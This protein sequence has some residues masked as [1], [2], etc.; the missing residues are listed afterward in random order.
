MGYSITSSDQ[1]ID[2]DT[3]IRGCEQ[4]IKAADELDVNDS[5]IDAAIST[6]GKNVCNISDNSRLYSEKVA[7]IGTKIK[8]LK[9]Q[10]VNIALEIKNEA[11]DIYKRENAIYQEYL[12]SIADKKKKDG[13]N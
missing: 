5:Y 12:K 8:Q 11:Q 13:D 4:I 9:V 2:K 7:D 6:S 3:I 10:I 1:I